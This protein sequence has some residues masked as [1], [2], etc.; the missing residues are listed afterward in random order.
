MKSFIILG[1]RAFVE[2]GPC[3]PCALHGCGS[4]EG[5]L[6]RAF[7]PSCRV[8]MMDI[9]CTLKD[10]FRKKLN[11]CCKFIKEASICNHDN[12]QQKH[13]IDENIIEKQITSLRP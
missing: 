1:W 2:E 6:V 11:M 3:A 12:R 8:W 5:L 4:R 7:A 10:P 13:Q 9:D